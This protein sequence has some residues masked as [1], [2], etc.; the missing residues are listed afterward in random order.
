M[1]SLIILV[2]AFVFACA[3]AGGYQPWPLPNMGWLA[4]AFFLLHLLLARV[5]I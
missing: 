3:A 5:P 2:F 1:V 4:F